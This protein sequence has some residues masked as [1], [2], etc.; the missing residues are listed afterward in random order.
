[1]SWTAGVYVAAYGHGGVSGFK[2]ISP[3]QTT[4]TAGPSGE[5]KDRTP[6]FKFHSSEA[7]STFQCRV[8][9]GAW[10]SCTSPR[11]LGKLSF[12]KHVFKVRARDA[13]GTPDPTPAKRRFKVVR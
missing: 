11:T 8:D 10:K 9:D 4:I 6:T 2:R 3:P 1:M 12:G 7:H 5:T 13:V